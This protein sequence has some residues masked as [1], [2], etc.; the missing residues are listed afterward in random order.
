MK[1]T[2]QIVTV[3][4]GGRVA[5]QVSQSVGSRVRVIVLEAAESAAGAG[6]S[7]TEEEWFQLGALA[8]V[9]EDDPEED[10]IWER[11]L[12]WLAT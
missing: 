4:E 12:P 8:A 5:L 7:L 11:Y 2:Q 3:G 9:T 1:A 10:A 6:R